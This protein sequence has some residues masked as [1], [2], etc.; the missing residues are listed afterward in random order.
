MG[1]KVFDILRKITFNNCSLREVLIEAVRK[2]NDPE[3]RASVSGG[4]SIPGQ[5][6]I[7][8]E[9]H[10]LTEN[11]MDIPQVMAIREDMERIEAHKLQSHFTEA[12]FVEAFDSV[13]GK[14]RP[15]EKGR[16]E[17]TFVPFAARNRDMQIGFGEPVLQQYER[18]C[19]DKEYIATCRIL[20]RQHLFVQGTRCWRL[21]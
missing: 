9:G 19:F 1:G 11:T 16:Y 12:F 17:V 20:S 3:V 7:L 2:G 15:R 8:I 13:D 6:C 10:A 14:A 21:R 5:G 4:G 18:I